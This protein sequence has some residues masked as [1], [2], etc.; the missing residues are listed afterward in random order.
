[1]LMLD[2]LFCI[3]LLLFLIFSICLAIGDFFH[4]VWVCLRFPLHMPPTWVPWRETAARPPHS[5]KFLDRCVF[6]VSFE[7]KIVFR[8]EALTL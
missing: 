4:A 5:L 6:V 8:E 2:A 3:S 7:S 1:M